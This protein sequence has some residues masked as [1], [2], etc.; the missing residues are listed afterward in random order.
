MDIPWRTAI[1]RQFGAA[2]D[3]LE[4]AIRACPDDLWHYQLYDTGSRAPAFAEYWYLVYH[5]LFWLDLYLTGSE[6]GFVPPPPFSLI[7]QDYYGPLPDR[8]YTKD[9]LQAYLNDCRERCQATIEATTDEAALRRCQFPWGEITFVE[10]LLYSMRHVVGH[11]AQLHL[12]LGQK[13]GS[14]PEWVLWAGEQG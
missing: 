11:T 8:P 14:G 5:A 10:L 12:V 2:I 1:W 7:E 3:D 9:E 6:E 4:N 13:S